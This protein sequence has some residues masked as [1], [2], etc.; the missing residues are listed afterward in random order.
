MLYFLPGMNSRL[1]YTFLE[2]NSSSDFS[3]GTDNGTVYIVRNLDRETQSQ[4]S[5]I[6][7]AMDLA[8]PPS[9]RKSTTAEVGYHESREYIKHT[10]KLNCRRLCL[11]LNLF[12]TSNLTNTWIRRFLGERNWPNYIFIITLLYGRLELESKGIL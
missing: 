1:M 9:S 2:G 11:L 12:I 7:I 10:D 6:V 8:E 3:I 4:Y 5:L